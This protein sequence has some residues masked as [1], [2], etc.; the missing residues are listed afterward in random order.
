[1]VALEISR[2]NIKKFP[3]DIMGKILDNA[4]I[5]DKVNTKRK[6]DIET[7]ITKIYNMNPEFS[8]KKRK[9]ISNKSRNETITQTISCSKTISPFNSFAKANTTISNSYIGIHNDLATLFK[10]EKTLLSSASL[11]RNSRKEKRLL[12]DRKSVV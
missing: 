1:M 6:Y 9:S 7:N 11:L 2:E 12:P 10:P 3:P 5:K 8:I 4:K